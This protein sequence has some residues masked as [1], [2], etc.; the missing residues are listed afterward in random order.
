M[1]HM[2]AMRP[3][4]PVISPQFPLLYGGGGGRNL[5]A[6]DE[7]E[8]IEGISAQLK[9]AMDVTGTTSAIQTIH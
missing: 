9:K 3:G 5:R 7:F 4:G 8:G 6:P 1:P 2:I